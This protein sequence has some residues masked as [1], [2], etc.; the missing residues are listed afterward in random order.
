MSSVLGKVFCSI[1]NTRIQTFLNTNK[2]INKSQI[3]FLP[4]HRAADHLYTLQTLISN[5]AHNKPRRKIFACFVDFKKAFDSVWHKGL[6]YKL[7][8][9]GVG[10]QVYDIIIKNI[11]SDT[12]C[13]IKIDTKRTEYFKQSMGVKQGC[14]LSPTLFNVYINELA[15]KLHNSTTPGLSEDQEIKR[16]MY[17]DDLVILAPTKDAQIGRAHV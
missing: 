4:K 15:T 14:S 12:Q 17:A 8:Q 9:S 11:H 3:G 16:L 7:I 10:G 2:I 13:C 6:F 1:I 5:H